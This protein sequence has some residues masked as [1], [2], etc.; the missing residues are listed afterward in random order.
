VYYLSKNK[1][2]LNNKFMWT[3][4]SL[5]NPSDR[6]YFIDKKIK[7]GIKHAVLT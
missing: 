7:F 6:A 4:Y 5:A 1:L 3:I 2:Y